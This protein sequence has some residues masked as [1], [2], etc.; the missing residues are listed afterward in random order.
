MRPDVFPAGPYHVQL[1]AGRRPL[2]GRVGFVT[3]VSLINDRE[4]QNLALI[5]NF[6]ADAPWSTEIVAKLRPVLVK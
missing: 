3:A 6:R 4:R 1:R 2:P 5:H